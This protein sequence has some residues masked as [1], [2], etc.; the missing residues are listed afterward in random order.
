MITKK[1]QILRIKKQA[2]QNVLFRCNLNS[3]LCI[4]W[5]LNFYTR[6]PGMIFPKI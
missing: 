6:S 4:R 1:N 5:P 2:F 3:E